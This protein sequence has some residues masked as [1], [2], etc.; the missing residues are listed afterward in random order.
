MRETLDALDAALAARRR[1]YVHCLGGRGRTG[2][3]VAC[4]LVR[5]GHRAEEA[6]ALVQERR[7]RRSPETAEQRRFVRRWPSGE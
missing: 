1:V 3:V 5:H 2:T 6:L 7:G 4:W